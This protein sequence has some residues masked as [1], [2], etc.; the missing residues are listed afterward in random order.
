MLDLGLG[1]GVQTGVV[2]LVTGSLVRLGEDVLLAVLVDGGVFDTDPNM[3]N[4]FAK[5]EE[6]EDFHRARLQAIRTTNR[7][8]VRCPVEDTDSDSLT[9]KAGGRS[10]TNGS[11]YRGY[12]EC[13]AQ[14]KQDQ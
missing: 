1:A 3:V 4:F 5:S 11:G 8:R 10:E 13:S 6:V 14:G 12:I 7:K 9:K 2:S